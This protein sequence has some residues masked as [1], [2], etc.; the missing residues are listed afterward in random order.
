MMRGGSYLLAQ[1][2][3]MTDKDV[4]YIG[5]AAA[6]QPTKLVQIISQLFFPLVALQSATN[7]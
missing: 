1:R 6:N 4:L 5:N 3:Y 7:F 2:F